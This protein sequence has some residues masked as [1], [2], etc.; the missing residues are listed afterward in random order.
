MIDII[1]RM[2]IFAVILLLICKIN[3]HIKLEKSIYKKILFW[4]IIILGFIVC[5]L[6]LKREL[7]TF[8]TPEELFDKCCVGTI[9]NVIYGDNSCII[10]YSSGKST[11]SFEFAEKKENGYKIVDVFSRKRVSYIF[12][13]TG[14][15]EVYHIN[16]TDDYYIVGIIGPI[17]K[18]IEVYSDDNS[19]VKSNIK[20]LNNSTFIYGFLDSFAKD[21]YIILDG[22]KICFENN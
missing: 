12:D 13:S 21:Y 6:P 5:L 1:I 19:I 16:G 11:Y 15:L 4:I 3:S 7:A 22:K 9:E 18:Y 14:T 8:R 17:E 20:Q 2:V 10:Y